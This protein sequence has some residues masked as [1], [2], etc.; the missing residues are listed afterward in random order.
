MVALGCEPAN[1][2][3]GIP[4]DSPPRGLSAFRIPAFLCRFANA[5]GALLMPDSSCKVWTG[6]IDKWGYGR[7]G[8]P[9]VK[10]HR[11]AWEQK[12][13]PIPKGMCVLHHC[14]NPP[15][16]NVDHLFLGTL[17]DNERD[18]VAKGRH[19]AQKKTHCLRGH[20]LSGDNLRPSFLKRGLRGWRVCLACHILRTGQVDG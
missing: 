15:C 12:H 6:S 10:I 19:A 20:L 11:L 7:T 5:G 17:S 3:L 13:G 2:E 1:Q 8:R 18:K 4:G 9:R 16:Y 14:D